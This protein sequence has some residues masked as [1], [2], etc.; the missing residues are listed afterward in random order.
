LLSL[1]VIDSK[2]LQHSRPR[3]NAE[4]GSELLDV[5]GG[6]ER[7]TAWSRVD[8]QDVRV[9]IFPDQQVYRPKVQTERLN[10]QDRLLDPVR[11][12]LLVRR[13]EAIALRVVLDIRRR[14]QV[15]SIVVLT[16]DTNNVSLKHMET[17][18]AG[19]GDITRV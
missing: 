7:G 4:N 12:Q 6:C 17:I 18:L 16:L 9:A 10:R 8:F 5:L 11:L 2:N 1:L 15:C 3:L 14:L 13:S 19:V